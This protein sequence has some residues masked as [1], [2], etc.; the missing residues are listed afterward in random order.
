VNRNLKL[1][2][3]LLAVFLFGTATGFFAND[4]LVRRRFRRFS[5]PDFDMAAHLAHK[6]A[7]DLD[8]NAAQHEQALAIFRETGLEMQA[9]RERS[10]AVF[11]DI[12]ERLDGRLLLLLDEQQAAR[13]R[14]RVAERNA[15]FQRH[16][17]PK[18]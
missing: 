7:K 6:M 11:S 16:A 4:Q 9:E 12:H 3:L 2:L 15:R 17:P 13:Y 5:N 8:L 18:K 10:F 14:E 1:V